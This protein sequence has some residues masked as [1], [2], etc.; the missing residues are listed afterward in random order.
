MFQQIWAGVILE[1]L[2]SV[3]YTKMEQWTVGALPKGSLRTHKYISNKSSKP[4][5]ICAEV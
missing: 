3:G 2:E 5:E 1:Q 4:G